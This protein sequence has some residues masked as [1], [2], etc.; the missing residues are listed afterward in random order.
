MRK[1]LGL[2]TAFGMLLVAGLMVG[3]ASADAVVGVTAVVLSPDEGNFSGSNQTIQDYQGSVEA[4]GWFNGSG[5]ESALNDGD[6]V[7]AILPAHQYGLNVGG[8]SSFQNAR[9]RQ[10]L[11]AEGFDA[12]TT[13][14]F[15]LSGPTDGLNGLLLWNGGEG[16]NS[17]RGFASVTADFSTDGST[18]FGSET[19]SF[20]QAITTGTNGAFDIVG[21]NVSF[22]NT[23]DN[24]NFV[25]FSN[26]NSFNGSIE[27]AGN[28]LAQI[29]E[30]RF[31]A[32]AVVIPEPSS[33]AL[34]S[35]IGVGVA[36]R[37]RKRTA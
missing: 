19:L 36:A 6:T 16:V 8:A 17:T 5:L 2:K 26:I 4:S 28:G 14:T 33:L 18:F 13:L 31:T 32:P 30:I 10:G 11:G 20:T 23:Y 34:L 24:V 12:G 27:A 9:L 21:E 3:N 35:C 22:A 37:R 1:V 29:S 25:R 15:T 7:P